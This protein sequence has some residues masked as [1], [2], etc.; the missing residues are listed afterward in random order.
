[1]ATFF[2]FLPSFLFILV[3]GPLVEATRGDLKF[4]APL[5]GITA[6]VVGVILNLALFF[7]YHVLWPKALNAL[8]HSRFAVLNGSS[9]LVGIAAFIALFRYKIGIMQVIGA[10][11]AG[12][13][14][15]FIHQTF[16]GI[17]RTQMSRTINPQELKSIL[18]NKNVTLID[19]RRKDDYAADN[20]AIPGSTWF[21]PSQI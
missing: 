18:G 13:A 17:R 19:V 6:A 20:N 14:D 3:G 7:A 12:R 8:T 5:T 10:C 21:D 2:T 11:A 1:M 15:L 9:A 16:S 4:T